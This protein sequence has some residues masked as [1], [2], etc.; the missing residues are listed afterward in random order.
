MNARNPQYNEFGTID[1]EIEHPIY[2]WI[3]F[4]AAPDDEAGKK[5]Y[6][7]AIAQEFG[8]IEPYVP[9]P[10]VPPSAEQIAALRK[11]AYQ[12]EADPLFFKAQRGEASMDDWLAKVAEIR[13]RYP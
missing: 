1:L 8:P 2:G 4:T 6:D 13:A 11:A 3:A 7:K 9:P 12:S 5:I 10:V